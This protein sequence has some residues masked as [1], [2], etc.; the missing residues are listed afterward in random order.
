MKSYGQFCPIAKAAEVF[1]ERW[2][3]LILR[4][5]AAGATRFSQLKRGIPLVSPT[6][7]SRR[8]RQLEAEGVIERRKSESGGSWTYHLTPAGDEFV[9][10]VM[11]LGTWGQRWTRRQLERHEIDLDLLIW[12]LENS[13]RADA[14]GKKRALVEIQFVDQPKHKRRWW[15][16][17]EDGRCELCVHEPGFEVDLYIFAGLPDLIYVY[18]GDLS[19][20]EAIDSG[21]IEAHGSPRAVKAL[22]RWL[23]LMPLADVKSRR[24]DA[25]RTEELTSGRR[26][27][28]A[29]A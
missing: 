3:A 24:P 28:T 29:A 27:R 8:L 12:G 16:L 11:A 6:L 19:L 14:F 1:C 13:V 4:D 18:R 10:V 23:G 9:P 2:T 17:N 26:A 25:P 15:F 21:R 20:R 5:M 7:L 22:P